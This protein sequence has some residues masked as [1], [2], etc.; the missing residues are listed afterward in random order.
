MEAAAAKSKLDRYVMVPAALLAAQ[1]SGVM[2]AGVTP[3]A[4]VV[5]AAADPPAAV[6]A[7]VVPGAAVVPLSAAVVLSLPQAASSRTA[8]A[9][10]AGRRRR[11][12]F[13]MGPPGW[14]GTSWA[15]SVLRA[16]PAQH[17]PL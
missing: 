14:S 12:R 9:P 4:V 11:G 3:G 10:A 5:V 7:V 6:V 17:H 16:V 15:R 2:P 1:R 8:R 13:V